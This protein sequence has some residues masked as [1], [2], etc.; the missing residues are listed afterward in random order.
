MVNLDGMLSR[1]RKY[2]PMEIINAI[3]YVIKTGC[4]WSM[5]PK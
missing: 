3:A 1:L 5:L 2:N 4:Q